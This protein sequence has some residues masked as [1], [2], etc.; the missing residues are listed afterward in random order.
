MTSHVNAL[1]PQACILVLI[2]SPRG[3]FYPPCVLICFILGT[4]VFSD[5][6][7]IEV[8]GKGGFGMVWKGEWMPGKK[9]VAIKKVEEMDRREVGYR[10]SSSIGLGLGL[11]LGWL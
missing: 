11:L 10:L 9:V 1:A 2:H 7:F 5:L 8:I 6:K 4:I 3:V